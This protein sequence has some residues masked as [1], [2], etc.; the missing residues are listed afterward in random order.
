MLPKIKNVTGNITTF[1]IF[2]NF[3]TLVVIVKNKVQLDGPFCWNYLN[4]TLSS[5]SNSITNL[6][7]VIPEA[8]VALTNA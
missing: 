1:K 6:W 5:V 8:S 4:T 2:G 7:N 3:A